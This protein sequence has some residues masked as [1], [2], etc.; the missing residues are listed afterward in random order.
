VTNSNKKIKRSP[1]KKSPSVGRASVQIKEYKECRVAK[2][3]KDAIFVVGIDGSIKFANPACEI[4][5]GYTPEEFTNNPGLTQKILY[6]ESVQK[7]INFWDEYKKNKIFSEKTLELIWIRK[8]KKIVHT[9]NTFTN[10]YD[11]NSEVVGFQ[12]VASDITRLK[13][14]EKNL[15]REKNFSEALIDS[16]PGVFY[17]FDREDRFIKWNRNMED[18]LGY[19]YEDIARMHPL[20]F[21]AEGEKKLIAERINDVFENGFATVEA[22]FLTK[23]GDLIP[24]FFTG[25]RIYIDNKD[26]LMGVGIDIT[27]RVKAESALRDKEER[28]RLI[29][30]RNPVGIF[31][32]NTHLCVTDFNERFVSILQSSKER[33][34]GFDMNT[35][36]DKSVLSALKKSVKGEEGFYEGFYSATTSSAKLWI[37][38][39][40]APLFDSKGKIM[41]GIGIMENISE[42]KNLEEQLK[43][44]QKLEAIGRL[45]G[46]IAHDF[47]NLLTI[48]L[49][50]AEMILSSLKKNDVSFG[51]IKEIYNAALRAADLTGQLLTFSRRQV[52]EP[53]IF[54]INDLVI[55]MD[56][57]LKRILGENISIN[58]VLSKDLWLCRVDPVQLEQAILNIV[59]NARDAMPKGGNLTIETAN[60]ILDKG[61]TAKYSDVVPG[62]YIQLA[63]SDTGSGM[64][65]DTLSH[66]FEPFY[67][68]KEL[69]KG[70]GLGLA[71]CYGFIKQS[72]GHIG[73]YSEVG[74]G[75]TFKIYLRH[76][77]GSPEDLEKHVEIIALPVGTETV[78]LVEDEDQVR[79]LSTDLLRKHGYTVLEAKDGKEALKLS[80]GFTDKIHLLLSDVI[81]PVVGGRE[82]YE[83]IKI[84]RPEIKALF[85]SG[86][87][88]NVIVHH[89]V[90]EQ[91][92]NFL[93]KPFTPSALLL[94][95]REAIEKK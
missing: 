77:V 70:T 18:V 86:Y 54:N 12:T 14:I 91:G 7:F 93:Q 87:T 65:E 73:V 10:I 38:M 6:T 31:Y 24:Y 44:S 32:Y 35:L 41:G 83:K 95:V 27:N 15:H 89:G 59:L 67:T 20:D 39:R 81:M 26:Y 85:M 22:N 61:Y 66:I 88:D 17:L 56:K 2:D 30:Q 23:N 68:K 57:M 53:K 69:G 9:Q 13:E 36:K 25:L 5:F 48:V 50:H 71:T 37:S 52:I 78:L 72:G 55:R 45:A 51:G 3:N 19:S 42:R 60:V 90:L 58:T 16:L 84:T 21:F 29:F 64:D 4:I 80:E 82:L 94:K 40:T 28:Y 76:E 63:I 79:N 11:E 34:K 46:G 43:Q 74:K 47:N 33:L 49:L 8:D 62:E 1:K 92:F 75:S